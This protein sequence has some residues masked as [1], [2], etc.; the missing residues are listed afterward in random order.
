MRAVNPQN[1]QVDNLN[2]SVSQ[3]LLKDKVDKSDKD[4]KVDTLDK[5]KVSL[6][7]VLNYNNTNQS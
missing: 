7:T 5:S 2:Q 3:N 4:D 1:D 6:S